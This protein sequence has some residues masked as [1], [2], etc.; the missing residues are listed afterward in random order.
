MLKESNSDVNLLCI[1]RL[2]ELLAHNIYHY[3]QALVIML[4]NVAFYID[5]STFLI[6]TTINK[7]KSIDLIFNGQ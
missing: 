5:Y 2:F 3:K 4:F 7:L 6:F 1:F